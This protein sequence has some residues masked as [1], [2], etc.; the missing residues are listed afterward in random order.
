MPGAKFFSYLENFVL[1]IPSARNTLV[2]V[3][4]VSGFLL[5][6]LSPSWVLSRTGP[7]VFLNHSIPFLCE[8]EFGTCHQPLH[9]VK[10]EPLQL[11][12]RS[13]P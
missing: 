11:L 5:A 1:F 10:P 12:T 4:H 3:F 7:F 6:E 13:T 9:G 2:L 8:L